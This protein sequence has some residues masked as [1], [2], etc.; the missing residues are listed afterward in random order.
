MGGRPGGFC[1]TG[2]IQQ[3]FQGLS[4]VLFA[5]IS[6]LPSALVFLFLLLVS[7]AF[8]CMIVSYRFVVFVVGSEASRESNKAGECHSGGEGERHSPESA[9][10]GL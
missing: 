5:F 4:E 2:V 7:A 1:V 9:S 3:E 8:S 10:A 6:A